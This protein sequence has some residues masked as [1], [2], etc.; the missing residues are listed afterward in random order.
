MKYF[1]FLLSLL[2]FSFLSCSISNKD[3]EPSS[4][5]DAVVKNENSLLWKIEK[6]GHQTSYLFGTMHLIEAEYYEFTP[7]MTSLIE[8]SDAVIMEIGGQPNPLKA[9]EMMSLKDGKVEDLF[10]SIQL[11]DLVEFMDK[12]M[13]ISPEQF[14]LT[15]SSM[16]PFFIL[17]TISQAFFSETAVSYD[18]N[19]MQM[20]AEKNIPLVGLETME[21][22]LGLFDKISAE[23]IANLIMTSVYNFEKE[24]KDT[25]KLQK[26]Y[27][28]QKV[29]KLIPLMKTQS[30][31][32]MEFEDLFLTNRNK[33]WI[34][35]IMKETKDKKCFIAVGAAH[36][37][38]SNGLIQLL[39]NE[40]F[41]LTAIEK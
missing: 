34:P 39:K 33:A 1:S 23:E 20:S 17:Q 41:T 11:K 4:N 3:K 30:P 2:F 19:I 31:E 5:I 21:E 7:H 27:S 16:K 8:S 24:K 6:D 28:E 32:F 26:L 12:K 13:N 14:H 40:G 22:Q 36:L 10:T 9:F 37:L 15:F 35:K 25:K 38:D 29:N 18:L